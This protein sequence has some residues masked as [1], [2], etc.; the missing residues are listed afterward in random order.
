MANETIDGKVMDD[1]GPFEIVT[2]KVGHLHRVTLVAYGVARYY[3]GDLHPTKDIA[4][5]ERGRVHFKL[6]SGN[7]RARLTG[8]YTATIIQS[9]PKPVQ[10]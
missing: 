6:A 10:S 3:I 4:E 5:T 9:I 8:Q 1:E 7:Y 2:E